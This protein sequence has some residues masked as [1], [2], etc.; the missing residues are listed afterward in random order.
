[1]KK[2]VFLLST[3]IITCTCVLTSCFSSNGEVDAP[4]IPQRDRIKGQ[5][6]DLNGTT[7]VDASSQTEGLKGHAVVQKETAR[8]L[9]EKGWDGVLIYLEYCKDDDL[10]PLKDPSD[11]VSGKVKLPTR[12]RVVQALCLP[13]LVS[14]PSH[15]IRLTVETTEA[16]GTSLS[17]SFNG[18]GEDTLKV[19]T[20]KEGAYVDIPHF[21]YWVFS[22][23]FTLK[24]L[25]TRVETSAELSEHCSVTNT[26]EKQHVKYTS[27]YGYRTDVKNPFVLGF[28]MQYCG[29]SVTTT[30]THDYDCTKEPG[31]EIYKYDQ[32]V[33]VFELCSGNQ[34]FKF[35]VYDKPV[36]RHIRF[37][38]DR[39]N[40]GSGMNP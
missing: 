36:S 35:E 26:N 17:C 13:P 20:N 39:H 33:Y 10:T 9:V 30:A 4:N 31:T 27:P 23:N 21:S 5:R 22:L 15:P 6:L 1:M 8:I 16:E 34:K 14:F 12:A 3:L 19:Y 40:G 11:L 38:S 32:N 25:E 7:H 24:C 2:F 28:L 29:K 37:E 18:M